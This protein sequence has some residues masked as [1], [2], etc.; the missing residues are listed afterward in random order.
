VGVTEVVKKPREDKRAAATGTIRIVLADDQNVVREAIKC[1]LEAEADLEVVGE[2]DD[3]LAVAPLVERLHP[4]VVILD[5][6]IPGLFGLEVTRQVRER[7]PQTAVIVLSRYV[8]EWYVT[9]ALRNGAAG[10]VAQHAEAGELIR[11]VR[12]VVQGERGSRRVVTPA[13]HTRR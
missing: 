6:A 10:Y 5:V 8:N 1:L 13:I 12:S 7:S 3:G 11:A 9:E 2:V 4:H